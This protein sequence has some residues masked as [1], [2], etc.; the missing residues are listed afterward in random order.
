MAH[1]SDKC[2][3][4]LLD[5]PLLEVVSRLLQC[6]CYI[7]NDSGITHLAALLGIPTVAIFGASDPANWRPLG[8]TVKVVRAMPTHCMEQLAVDAVMEALETFSLDRSLAI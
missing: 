1:S 6:K 2:L 3:Q 8:P 7:G 4:T 5:A